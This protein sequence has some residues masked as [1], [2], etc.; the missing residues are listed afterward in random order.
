MNKAT[1]KSDFPPFN[2]PIIRLDAGRTAPLIANALLDS[3]EQAVGMSSSNSGSQRL[4]LVSCGSPYGVPCDRFLGEGRAQEAML[5][6]VLVEVTA[7]PY[8]RNPL[9]QMARVLEPLAIEYIGAYLNQYGHEVA[10]IQQLDQ[11]N[12]AVVAEIVSLRAEMVGISCMTYSFPDA[13]EIAQAIKRQ[14]PQT[15]TV[16]GGYH[17]LGLTE[18]PPGFDFVVKGEGELPTRDLA[19]FLT[20]RRSHL[21]DIPGLRAYRDPAT[22]RSISV[23]PTTLGITLQTLPLPFRLPREDYFSMS[24]GENLP[25]TRLACI[26]IGRGCP[27]RCDFCC[28]PQ[29]FHGRHGYRDFDKVVDEIEM[30]QSEHGVNTLNLRDE[31]FAPESK[32]RAFCEKL[33]Q[34]NISVSWRA[35]A[36]FGTLRPD[37]IS[38]MAQAGCHMLFY[39]IEA[40]DADTL[41]LRR[42]SFARHFEYIARDIQ[43]AQSCGIFV[44]GGFIVGHETDTE[45]TFARHLEFL[46]QV[47]PDEL[48]VS[49]LTPFPG[50]PLF[51]EASRQDRIRER[52]WRKYDCEHPIL[53]VAV[54]PD[55]LIELRQELYANYYSSR[56]WRSHLDWRISKRPEEADTIQRYVQFIDERLTSSES[57]AVA[58]GS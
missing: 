6:I 21:L 30:L 34:R 53:D 5:R 25:D 58:N 37:T 49:F 36:T 18:C 7:E 52:D 44:R 42:K 1:A 35:F 13:Q 17:V 24:M 33:L 48:Y 10:L 41:K 26:V 51:A 20:G 11:S 23:T 22:E 4:F 28:T 3:P 27:F 40:S 16:L 38:L 15:A 12:E 14:L 8:R 39:G 32:V 45:E 55:R 43:H 31:T 2:R 19:D 9:S 29:V 46:K 54:P 57:L 50:T 47:R 56:E